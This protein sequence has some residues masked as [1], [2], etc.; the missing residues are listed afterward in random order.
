MSETIFREQHTVKR[1]HTRFYAPTGNKTE[2]RHRASINKEG[3]RELIRDKEVAIYDLIQSHREECEIE[4]IIRRA[5]E[6]DYNALNAVN[7]VFED[8]TNCPASIAEAQQYIIDAK[9]EFEKLP[10][11]IKAKFEYN[12][13][14]YIAELGNDPKSWLE[15]TGFA[16]EIKINRQEAETR[17][18]NDANFQKAMKILAA[19]NIVNNPAG[20]KPKES[21]VKDNE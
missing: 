20:D 9:N 7:G 13:E 12:A 15:K 6:G 5:V 17:A 3:V 16:D 14:M 8:I 4:N 21:E 11:D 10:K 18:E 1:N 2:M 19:G